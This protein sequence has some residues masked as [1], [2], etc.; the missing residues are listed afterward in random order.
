MTSAFV[1]LFFF[2]PI[3]E[4]LVFAA[5]DAASINIG[6]GALTPD[7]AVSDT[8]LLPFSAFVFYALE[9]LVLTPKPTVLAT[10]HLVGYNSSKRSP[11]NPFSIFR[12]PRRLLASSPDNSGVPMVLLCNE[13]V[14]FVVLHVLR[15]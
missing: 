15:F 5:L 3:P 1:V 4:N 10:V 2:A 8:R 6:T 7:F 13:L 12:T 14:V 9:V 11:T